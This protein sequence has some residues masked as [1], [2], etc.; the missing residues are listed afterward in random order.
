MTALLAR[1][2][3]IPNILE[4]ENKEKLDYPVND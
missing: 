1:G 3:D 4:N 2:R